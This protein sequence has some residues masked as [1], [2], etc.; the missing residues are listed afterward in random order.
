MEA[1][2][3]SASF[4]LSAVN[5]CF[6]LFLLPLSRPRF[7]QQRALRALVH[8]TAQPGS[9]ESLLIWHTSSQEAQAQE[10]LKRSL[11][12]V[13]AARGLVQVCAL[14]LAEGF[15]VNVQCG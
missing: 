11:L 10:L 7:K 13:A 8:A 4:P 5:C 2:S 3:L 14:L 9:C 12:H 6:V 15:D 1:G